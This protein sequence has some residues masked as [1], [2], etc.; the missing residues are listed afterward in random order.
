[1][2]GKLEAIS[3][4]HIQAHLWKVQQRLEVPSS[5]QL[6]DHEQKRVCVAQLRGGEGV[7]G[8][9]VGRSKH[10]AVRCGARVLVRDG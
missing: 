10:G 9:L 6:G 5:A 4:A 8:A 7:G 3:R 2:L 1:M